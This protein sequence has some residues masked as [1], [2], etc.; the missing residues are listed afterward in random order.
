MKRLFR[1]LVLIVIFLVVTKAIP[2]KPFL[3]YLY[4]IHHKEIIYE[5]AL[6]YDL[7]PFLIAAMIHVESSWRAN[8]VSPKGATGLMQ[9]MPETANWVA[10][11]LGLTVTQES[12]TDPKINIKLGSWYLNYLNQQFPTATAALAAYNGGLGNVHQ[13]L[14][15]ER[16]DGSLETASQ[17]PFWETRAYVH[18]VIKTWNFYQE[19]YDYQWDNGEES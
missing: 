7:D 3:Q 2:F 13:W 9:L 16:W 12:L 6:E 10:E 19:I 8:A 4:P 15:E 11:Q 1:A 14:K 18:K 5:N 17:I